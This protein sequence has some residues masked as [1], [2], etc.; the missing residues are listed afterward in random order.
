M[1]PSGRTVSNIAPTPIYLL[2][3]TKWHTHVAHMAKHMDM[4]GAL[5]GGGPGPGL[6]SPPKSGAASR[7]LLN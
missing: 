3:M 2:K 6:L 4:L 7:H 1:L 5:F